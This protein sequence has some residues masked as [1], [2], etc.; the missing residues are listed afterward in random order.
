MRTVEICLPTADV[1]QE[2]VRVLAGLEG[3]FELVSGQYIL[4]AKSLMGIFTFDLTRPL[5]LKIYNDTTENLQAV[6]PF[7]AKG[8]ACLPKE[9]WNGQ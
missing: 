3:D 6:Q 8:A 2:F 9:A 4:D 7:V 5:Q 1:V